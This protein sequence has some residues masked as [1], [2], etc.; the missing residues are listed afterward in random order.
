MTA[1]RCPDCGELAEPVGSAFYCATKDCEE[2]GQ[3]IDDTRDPDFAQPAATAEHGAALPGPS[4]KTGADSESPTANQ[5]EP[6]K[7]WA[8]I[9][10]TEDDTG[11]PR[12]YV[13]T[14][15]G[16]LYRDI[17]PTLNPTRRLVMALYRTL[18]NATYTDIAREVGV[19]RERVRQIIEQEEQRAQ[20]FDHDQAKAD[21]QLL[22]T[23]IKKSGMS[24]R[25]F[26]REVLI[27]DVRQVQRILKAESTLP[28]IV[29]DFLLK[30]A[31]MDDPASKA[32]GGD[33]GE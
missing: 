22:S 11:Q 10:G 14:S 16:E 2:F 8:P 21:A 25:Q 27:R 30:R 12:G 32:S 28:A 13:E 24:V 18:P 6:T 19:S 15:T 7:A 5:I 26:A 1:P 23:A 33:N 4:V 3:P 17:R 31:Q 9:Q 29:R 20:P